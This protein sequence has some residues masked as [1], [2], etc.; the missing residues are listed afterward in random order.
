MT[1]GPDSTQR[2]P[3]PA[4]RANEMDTWIATSHEHGG[5]AIRIAIRAKSNQWKGKKTTIT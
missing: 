1:L 4:V 3:V 5:Q 2:T